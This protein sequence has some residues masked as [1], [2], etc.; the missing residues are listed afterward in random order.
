[1]RKIKTNKIIVRL[2]KKP[3]YL[4]PELCKEC[5]DAM[6]LRRNNNDNSLFWECATDGETKSLLCSKCKGKICL[7]SRNDGSGK[8][9]GCGNYKKNKCKFGFDFQDVD[10]LINI[11]N[12]EIEKRIKS[13]D[14]EKSFFSKLFFNKVT[15]TIVGGV[16]TTI[17]IA[18]LGINEPKD[19]AKSDLL[20]NEIEVTNAEN[21]VDEKNDG[22]VGTIEVAIDEIKSEDIDNDGL[23]NELEIIIYGTDPNNS[24]TDGD[25]YIDGEEVVGGYN[26]L[27]TTRFTQEEL[28]SFELKIRA[29]S[30]EVE[31]IK[32][33]TSTMDLEELELEKIEQEIINEEDLEFDL[34]VSSLSY[35]LPYYTHIGLPKTRK[36]CYENATCESQKPIVFVLFNEEKNKIYRCDSL[37]CD[38]Y[39]T[40][41]ET[42]GIYN[43]IKAVG[44]DMTVKVTGDTFSETVSLGLTQYISYGEW[45]SNSKL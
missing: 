39:D 11:V 41:V 7:K 37:P 16:L 28:D 15:A 18:N 42:S 17:I 38:E 34:D 5:K 12:L 20:K 2:G 44:R 23:S 43:I 26:P 13:R 21:I 29:L 8:F 4:K 22:H 9:Y 19:Y 45:K 6:F 27:N 25:G 14:K 35:K 32:V 31:E 30:G 36:V 10:N 40:T 33:L 1:M 24:D 3:M